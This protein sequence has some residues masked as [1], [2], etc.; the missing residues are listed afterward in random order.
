MPSVGPGSVLA[1]LERRLETAHQLARV[2]VRAADVAFRRGFFGNGNAPVIPQ[3]QEDAPPLV[4]QTI[5]YL[6][7]NAPLHTPEWAAWRARMRAP[8]LVGRW[9]VTAHIPGRGKYYGE[10]VIEPGSA[11]D[12]FQ[13]R[14]TLRSATGGSTLT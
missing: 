6:A 10:M 2:L 12:Q 1:P 11:D 3:A 8:K 13:T 9:L 7:K 14:V 5:D 4:D